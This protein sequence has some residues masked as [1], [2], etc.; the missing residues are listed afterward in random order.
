MRALIEATQKF[1]D[2][3]VFGNGPAHEVKD[4]LRDFLGSLDA[5]LDEVFFY[6]TGHG[7]ETDDEFFFCFSDFDTNSPHTTGL[8]NQ[9]LHGLIRPLAPSVFVKVIDAC[10]SGAQLI[11]STHNLGRYD[12]GSFSSFIQMAACQNNQAARTGTPLSLFTERFIDAALAK[13]TGPVYYT[14]IKAKLR[15]VFAKDNYQTPHFVDQGTAREMFVG[16]ASLLATFSAATKDSTSI[17][18][19]APSE[20]TSESEDRT[21]REELEARIDER[22]N[23][24]Q[25]QAYI[26]DLSGTISNLV[27][28]IPQVT[29]A[30]D[31]E[32]HG[33]DKYY[34]KP[35]KLLIVPILEREP[36][37]DRLV[38]TSISVP[39]G[40]GLGGAL[41]RATALTSM[42]YQ[43]D[44]QKE[45]AYNLS[46]S[47]DLERV[48][49]TVVLL[50]KYSSLQKFSITI[51]FV[52]SFP[53][54]YIFVVTERHMMTN[55]GKFGDHAF[56][57]SGVWYRRKWSEPS[58]GIAQS[59]RDKVSEHI[60]DYFKLE[61]LD[62]DS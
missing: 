55:W 59:I 58:D 47:C 2:V 20:E 30:Y 40:S 18:A 28:L 52:P 56:K 27:E 32:V 1:S 3:R 22:A 14:D 5:G 16:D 29:A 44:E 48:Q 7:V 60:V 37:T 35:S 62:N 36:R 19:K 4:E 41:A 26:D 54:C 24:E 17:V 15:D 50:P 45:K 43:S 34:H 51:S 57:E 13:G 61:G 31:L 23:Q 33:S 25:A 38:K 21:L 9:E 46:L 53:L 39:E 6:F 42:A 49:Q 8:S 12:K 11:K 10:E